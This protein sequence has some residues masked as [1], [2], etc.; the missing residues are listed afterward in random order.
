MTTGKD[1]VADTTGAEVVEMTGPVPGLWIN[2]H[3]YAPE[4]R[5]N[6]QALRVELVDSG[7]NGT[8]YTG[9]VTGYNRND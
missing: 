5:G 7:T 6:I 8:R 3:L 4:A 1:V 2:Q 9:R